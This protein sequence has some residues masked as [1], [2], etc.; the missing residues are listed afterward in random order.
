MIVN[1]LGWLA[2][3]GWFR[4]L[5]DREVFCRE[6]GASLGYVWLLG[7][8]QWRHRDC[9]NPQDYPSGWAPVEAV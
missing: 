6:C 7:H 3:F 9:T 5:T 8:G 4:Q 1:L 2:R